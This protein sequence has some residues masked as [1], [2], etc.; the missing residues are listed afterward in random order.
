[1][2]VKRMTTLLFLGSLTM[3]LLGTLV[4]LAA[5]SGPPER[6]PVPRFEEMELLASRAQVPG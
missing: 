2:A 1:M 6:Q 5:I 3:I 4:Y